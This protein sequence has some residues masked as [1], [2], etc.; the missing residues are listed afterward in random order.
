MTQLWCNDFK[1]Y[2]GE[3]PDRTRVQLSAAILL[4]CFTSARTGE[5]HE[6]TARRALARGD[7]NKTDN[8]LEARVLAACYKVSSITKVCLTFT[9]R[10]ALSSHHRECGRPSITSAHLP[11][12]VYQR[13]LEKTAMGASDPCLLRHLQREYATLSQPS[14]ILPP[15]GIIRW[16]I[17][18]L[19][20]GC[21]D[22]GC[23]G[24][25]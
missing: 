11:A 6:S 12:G 15:Y 16:G 5:V 9:D 18:G 1:E 20:I 24:Q 7:K 3:P 23:G 25:L 4:Y 8:K 2:R 17:S 10:T 13:L 22:P 14:H 21:G 19:L